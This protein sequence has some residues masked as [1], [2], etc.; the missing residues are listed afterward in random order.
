MSRRVLSFTFVFV[1]LAACSSASAQMLPVWLMV[2]SETATERSAP[3]PSYGELTVQSWHRQS[4]AR[5]VL[6]AGAGMVASAAVHLAY[7]V[8]TRRCEPDLPATNKRSI[9]AAGVIGGV[10]LSMVVGGATWLSVESRRFG[11]RTSWQQ[12]LGAVGIASLS[13]IPIQAALFAIW[14]SDAVNCD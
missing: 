3:V 14:F 4:R 10:G 6:A 12:R 7:A 8:P 9:R 2:R 1:M 5:S 11:A 13:A